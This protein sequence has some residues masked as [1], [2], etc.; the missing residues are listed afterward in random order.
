MADTEPDD[1]ADS[2]KGT[3][4]V[5]RTMSGL[6]W[7]YLSSGVT[8]VLQLVV[9]AI[10]ARLLYPSDFGLVA[11][12]AVI[13]SFGQYFAQMGVGQAVVQRPDISSDDVRVAFT[14]SVLLGAGFSA[15]FW[16]AAPLSTYLFHDAE[17]V[18]ILRVSGLT[19]LITGFTTTAMA[20]LRRDLRF[21]AVAVI[22]TASYALIYAPL[23]VALAFAGLG[24]WSLV[25]AGLGQYT[26]TAFLAYT[27]SRHPLRPSLNGAALR[28]LYS[29]GARVSGISFLEFL[30]S[31]IGPMWIGNRLGADALGVYNRAFNLIN[32]PAYYFTTSLSRVMYSSMSRVQGET[33]RLRDTYMSLTTVFAA[34][35]MPACWGAAGASRQIVLVLLGPRW[36][37]AIPVFV[38]LALAAPFTFLAHLSGVISEVTAT[39]NPKLILSLG[40]LVVLI[41][42]LVVLTPLGLVGYA[43]AFAVTEILLYAAYQLLMKTVLATTIRRLLGGQGAGYA[44]GLLILAL[45]AAIGFLGAAGELPVWATLIVQIVACICCLT[46]FTLRGFSGAIWAAMHA[47]LRWKDRIQP[48]TRS[49]RVVAWLDSHAAGSSDPRT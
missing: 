14:S 38:V 22:E 24:A 13:L 40:R 26:M 12:A 15:L 23:G 25:A 5:G 2:R 27:F 1:P 43:L 10:L 33:A 3:D 42:L 30:G 34:L 36:T 47:G 20:L 6:R 45:T 7:S 31:N 37:E 4:L 9:T 18:P 49:G 11:M 19:F 16:L 28:A 29:F 46:W 32:L 8:A 41:V 48:N 39:L 44:I 35:L 21:R 17:V